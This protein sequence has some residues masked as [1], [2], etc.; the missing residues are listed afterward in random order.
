MGQVFDPT[1]NLK[2]EARVDY[3]REYDD[4]SINDGATGFKGRY[5]N[6]ALNGNINKN[7]SYS[8]R[9]RLNKYSSDA[10]F[11]D[12][13][14]WV[15]LSYHPNQNWE[16]SAGKQI[17]WIGGY[18]YDKAPIDVYR[19]SEFWNNVAC[20][21]MG[22]SVAYN[23]TPGKDQLLFQVCESPFRKMDNSNMYAYNLMWN[24][25]H[26]LFSSIYSVNMLEYQ[27]D[28]YISYISL[29]NM[30]RFGKFTVTVDLMNR[31][32]S[33]QAYFFKDFTVIG[34]ADYRINNNFNIFLKGTYDKNSTDNNGDYLVMS[35]T[36]M[37]ML[38]G[39]VE[40]FPLKNSRHDVRLHAYYFYSWGDNGNPDGTLKNKSS[41]LDLGLT[42]RVNLLTAK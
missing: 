32:T 36:D 28:H 37:K 25:H 35:G 1:I 3:T 6:V 29:G 41:Y 12:A 2:V 34:E 31:A 38:G 23:I 7:F 33:H 21:Q 14:D 11:F 22:G 24:G 42:W 8:W 18:E 20:Y 13:T 39:G 27:K 10:T 9:Q 40:Y 5:L 19:A 16:L 17:V 4:G 15:Y 30:F 26:G